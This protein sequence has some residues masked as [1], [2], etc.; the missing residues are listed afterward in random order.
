LKDKGILS[1]RISIPSSHAHSLYFTYLVGGGIIMFL[2]LAFFWIYIVWVIYKLTIAE[3]IDWI[4]ISSVSILL[5]NL[6]IG[7]VNTTFHHEHAIFTMFVLGLLI[8]KYRL[9]IRRL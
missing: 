7:L 3:G 9:T 5:I 8:S 1:S 6:V 4:T 2:A